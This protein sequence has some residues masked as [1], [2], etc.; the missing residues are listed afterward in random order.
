MSDNYEDDPKNTEATARKER[1]AKEKITTPEN[2]QLADLVMN[3]WDEGEDFLREARKDYQLNKAFYLNRQWITWNARKGLPE[4]LPA[5]FSDTERIRVTDNQM[6]PRIDTLLGVLTERDLVFEGDPSDADDSSMSGSQLAEGILEAARQQQGWETIR[7]EEVLGALL[8][9]ISAVTLEWNGQAGEKLWINEQNNQV[10]GTGEVQLTPMTIDE[11]TLEPGSRTWQEANW[12]VG[13]TGVPCAQVRDHFGLDWT[14]EAD[15]DSN[16]STTYSLGGNGQNAAASK[17]CSVYVM[18][19]RPNRKCPKGRCVAVV[20]NVAVKNGEWKFPFNEL[21]IALFRQGMVPGQWNGKTFVTAARPVQVLLNYAKSNIAEHMKMASNARLFVPM[22]ALD[23]VNELTDEAGEIIQYHAEPN[24]PAPD[25]KTPPPLS[26][27]MIQYAENLKEELS[28]ILHANDVSRGV[29]PGDR[30]SGLALSILAEKNNT[31]LGPMAHDQSEGWA[32]LGTQALKLYGRNVDSSREATIVSPSGVPQKWS[33]QGS[34]LRGQTTVRVPID[35][36]A[37]FTR[38]QMLANLQ[39]L[40]QLNPTAFQTI[41]H[42]RLTRLMGLSSAREM[43]QGL[44]P[45]I[46]KAHRENDRMMGGEPSQ[47]AKFD[48]HAKHIAEHNSFR[49]STNYEFAPEDIKEL[50]DMHIQAHEALVQEELMEQ[51]T[52]NS[53]APGLG[54][55]PQGNDPIGSAIPDPFSMSPQ[56]SEGQPLPPGPPQ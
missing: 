37:P 22:G 35:A 7:R 21:N 41:P 31:P 34:D 5:R 9:G 30:N 3:R 18:Y 53:I 12:W 24:M 47:P 27:S 40:Q 48:D 55:L 15:F 1:D 4:N 51:A 20:N 28:E 29:A 45:D 54:A 44:N 49:K 46:A 2:T 14:P 50:V 19:E 16:R 42:E 32:R 10:I 6:E 8:G 38:A 25:Y 26:N 33:W 23:D 52:M 17:L 11:F 56:L 13:L 39:N 36:V 43:A